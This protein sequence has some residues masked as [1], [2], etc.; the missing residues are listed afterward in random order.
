[1]KQELLC[2]WQETWW[3]CQSCLSLCLWPAAESPAWVLLAAL[4][5]T[6]QAGSLSPVRLQCANQGEISGLENPRI[7]EFLNRFSLT[8]NRPRA[9]LITG[10]RKW[11]SC[12]KQAATKDQSLICRQSRIWSEDLLTQVNGSS[13]YLVPIF[14]FNN[15]L[16]AR[17]RRRKP[18]CN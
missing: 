15:A 2:M 1:M 17:S 9:A 11:L 14:Y 5:G 6:S 4:T 18:Q 10:E 3:R 16:A 12:F 8:P 7:A 13:S